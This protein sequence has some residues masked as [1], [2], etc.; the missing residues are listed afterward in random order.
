MAVDYKLRQEKKGGFLLDRR[1]G[2]ALDL[3]QPQL[4]LLVALH[5]AGCPP[6]DWPDAAI[7][8]YFGADP[9]TGWERQRSAGG[10]DLAPA[11]PPA[12]GRLALDQ[13]GGADGGAA[14]RERAGVRVRG[15]SG[16]A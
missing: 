16:V 15:G 13:P 6:S 10:S 2:T 11:R 9:A 7:A 8:S 3:S 14:E 5:T 1:Q 12:A 4:D